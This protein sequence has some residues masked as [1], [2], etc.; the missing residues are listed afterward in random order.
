MKIFKLSSSYFWLLSKTLNES[1]LL[2]LTLK[3]SLA[4][5]EFVCW[6][7]E[8]GVEGEHETP[9][10]VGGLDLWVEGELVWEF[11]FYE[12]KSWMFLLI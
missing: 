5:D 4:V 11:R 6:F 1:S 8:E 12:M 9:I 10:G 7:F 2:L 3:V